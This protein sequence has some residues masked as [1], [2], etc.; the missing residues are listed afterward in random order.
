MSKFGPQRRSWR[1]PGGE[2]IA[3]TIG[4]AFEA[5][6]YQSQYRTRDT[7]GKINSLSLSYAEYGA[8]VGGWRLLDLLD[9]YGI[10]SHVSA[11]GLA[12]ERY[13]EVLAAAVQAGHEMVGHGWANDRLLTAMNIDEEREDIERTT[14]AILAAT[15]T[16]PLGWASPGASPSSNTLELLCEAGYQWSGDDASD[17]I[18]FMREVQGRSLAI[19]PQTNAQHNDMQIFLG[20]RNA[21]SIIWESFKESF[22]LLY[23][24][25]AQGMPGWTEIILHCHIGGRPVLN[26]TIRKCLEYVRN[27]D[28]VWCTT[29]NE[30]AKWTMMDRHA[31]AQASAQSSHLKVS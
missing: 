19:L 28:E 24:E 12:A 18:P 5:F 11:N 4:L 22:D 9:E 30:I 2:R 7:P 25:G 6:E 14:G 31:N 23:H 17:D 16:S 1:W 20:P 15:G 10:R 26:G 13:P 29:R 27:H 8:R 3:F 21:P